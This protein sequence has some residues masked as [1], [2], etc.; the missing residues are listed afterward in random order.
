MWYVT[1]T[2]RCPVKQTRFRLARDNISVRGDNLLCAA[3]L[4]PV[5]DQNRVAWNVLA[6]FGFQ[7]DDIG[8]A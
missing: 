4:L 2:V 3:V 7:P 1:G 8:I 5:F 6:G